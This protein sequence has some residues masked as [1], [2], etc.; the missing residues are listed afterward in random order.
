MTRALSYVLRQARLRTGVLIVF[1]ALAA[2]NCGTDPAAPSTLT[3]SPADPSAPADP[4]AGVLTDTPTL[5]SV[6]ANTSPFGPVGLWSNAT[7]VNWGPKPFTFS[8]NATVPS[9][10]MTQISTAR[11]MGQRL[12]LA[13]SASNTANITGGK[14]D[15]TKWKSHI[16]AYNTTAIRNA[17]AAGV[18]DGTIIGNMLIDEP[19]T[20]RWGGNIDK[21]TIDQMASYAKNIFPTL[22]MGLNHGPP[23]YK[24]HTEQT[25]KVLD[26]VLYQYNWW[27]TTGNV[28]AWRDAVLSRARADGVT[29]ALSL[30][31]LGGG[32]QDRSGTWD[33]T[34]S[35]QAGKGPYYP[36]CQMTSDQL[37]SWG[38]AIIGYGCF[39]LMW[40][41]D[42][43]YMNKSSNKTAFAT[44]ATYSA[45]KPRRSCKRP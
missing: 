4:T 38:K 24:W 26:Y 44:L 29:P 12:V 5:A 41:Y 13:L 35:G 28:T 33:C 42:D 23:G 45:S 27:I 19:E 37:T 16:N 15:F 3:D 22:P 18:S 1:A 25:Y 32:V 14:F 8:Q 7:S 20:N 2:T 17:V 6:V 36:N 10:V 34:G 21:R 39:T 9:N 30:N 31:V 43:L 40:R 11:N